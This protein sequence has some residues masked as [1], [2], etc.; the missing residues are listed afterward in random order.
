[1]S[2]GATRA[3]GVSLLPPVRGQYD[4][5]GRRVCVWAVWVAGGGGLDVSHGDR[6]QER[7]LFL[8]IENGVIV[9]ALPHQCDWWVI[10]VAGHVRSLMACL[11]D[12]LEILEGRREGMRC[13]GEDWD[14]PCSRVLLRGT[15]CERHDE[16]RGD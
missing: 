10:G 3:P 14:E 8:T 5:D 16:G 4:I 15:Q 7:N 12:A 6:Y 2:L 9:A 1:M 13:P 11:G